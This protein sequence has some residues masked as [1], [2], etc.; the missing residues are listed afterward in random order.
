ME[1]RIYFDGAANMTPYK[2]VLD[3]L[4]DVY[5]SNTNN[6]SSLHHEGIQ[7]SEMLE[8]ARYDIANLI[9]CNADEI[10]FVSGASEAIAWVAKMRTLVVHPTSHHSVMEAKKDCNPKLIKKT[11]IAIPYY[12]SETGTKNELAEFGNKDIF[13]DLTASIGKEKIN[14]HNMPQVKYACFSAHK[15]GGVLG[16]GVLYIKKNVQKYIQPLIWGSQERGCRGGTENYPAIIAMA[17]ALKICYEHFDENNKHI[18]DMGVYIYNNIKDIV[19]V[20]CS[21]NVINITFK[22]LSAQSAVSLFDIYGVA[23]SAGSACNSKSVEPSQTLLY[24][25]YS[26]ED[27][28]KTIRVSL[29][30]NN[31]LEECQRFIKILKEVVDTYDSV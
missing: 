27:A 25:S 30:V 18:K 2:A 23:I 24:R 31:T 4:Q 10:F 5:T 14:L 3:I 28:L 11:V 20:R 21:Y 19:K 7:A 16:A 22:N 26:R 8:K 13:L 6:P 15:F 29:T 12:D 17:E 1:E 9:G